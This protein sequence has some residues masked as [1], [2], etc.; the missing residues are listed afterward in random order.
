MYG[1][2]VNIVRRGKCV[3]QLLI[4]KC[5]FV[6]KAK[7]LNELVVFLFDEHKNAGFCFDRVI[8]D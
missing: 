7:G 4:K 6:I 3:H 5:P 8:R 1:L 2:P